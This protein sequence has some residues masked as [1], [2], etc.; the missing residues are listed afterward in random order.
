VAWPADPSSSSPMRSPA[1][2]ELSSH[3]LLHLIDSSERCIFFFFSSS[4]DPLASFL[5]FLYSN[6]SRRPSLHT[7]GA[8]TNDYLQEALSI[9]SRGGGIRRRRN[10]AGARPGGERSTEAWICSGATDGSREG[11]DPG[12]IR[13]CRSSHLNYL[14]RFI[15][16]NGTRKGFLVARGSNNVIDRCCRF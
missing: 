3:K 6:R 1:G 10:E 15:S 9:L 8:E 7:A 11:T 4:T 13:F 16:S 2:G 12:S 5:D 14:F